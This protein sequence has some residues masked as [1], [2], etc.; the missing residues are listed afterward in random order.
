MGDGSRI[1]H[2]GGSDELVVFVRESGG[3]AWCVEHEGR[4]RKELEQKGEG[5]RYQ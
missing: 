5:A 1:R 2:D 4:K 3:G